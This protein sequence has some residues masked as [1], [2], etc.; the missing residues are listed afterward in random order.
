MKIYIE[1]FGIVLI[2]VLLV[3]VGYALGYDH[4][5]HK[6]TIKELVKKIKARGKFTPTP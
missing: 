5:L 6:R 4:G 1:A 2:P 3:G